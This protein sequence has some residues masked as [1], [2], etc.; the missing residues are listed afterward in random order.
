M[1][2]RN[3]MSRLRSI[4]RSKAVRRQTAFGMFL[5]PS[6]V[7][8]VAFVIVPFGDVIRRSFVTAVTQ[9]WNGFRNY[10]LVFQN[11]VF[12]LA[13]CNTLRFI[14]IGIPLLLLIGFV[15][16]YGLCS[17]KGSRWI[18][19]VYLFPLAMPTATVVLVWK[20][21]F[22]PQGFFNKLLT[23][24]G[25]RSG[26]WEAVHTDYLGTEAAFG[27]LVF[28]Y[29]WKNLG[30]TVVLWMAGILGIPKELGEAAWVDGANGW[31]RLIYILLP[32]LKGC[33]FTLL[34]LLFLNSF[35]IYRE[36]Y[37]VAGAYPDKSM[38]LLQHLFNNWFVNLEFDKLAAASVCVGTVLFG[39][40]L[41][42]QRLWRK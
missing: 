14:G 12:R 37:L 35:K 29:L 2:G 16:A 25:I 33:L 23:Q 31:Q 1:H 36:A 9:K 26:L 18:K 39:A 30:Y 17:T 11:E 19:A 32:Q 8:T 42:L 22:A 4:C 40:V 28:S 10:A 34:V 15:L 6:F 5:L 21:V 38:Y 27:V 3:L 41:L 7:G 13:V 20:M 24:I